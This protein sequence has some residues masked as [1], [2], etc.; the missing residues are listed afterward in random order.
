LWLWETA[1]RA[2]Y[3][4][5]KNKSL[6]NCCFALGTYAAEQVGLAVGVR[7]Q[8]SRTSNNALVSAVTAEARQE[9]YASENVRHEQARAN[10]IKYKPR[11]YK[12]EERGSRRRGEAWAKRG[13][14]RG[15][16]SI[17]TNVKREIYIQ[18]ARPLCACRKGCTSTSGRLRTSN[19]RVSTRTHR[20]V[21]SKETP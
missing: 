13:I 19:L 20:A 4:A 1:T 7:I 16:C 14:T 5:F 10:P 3:S 15:G 11:K 6:V 21:R 18:Q 8:S 2:T 17:E 9:T 12:D